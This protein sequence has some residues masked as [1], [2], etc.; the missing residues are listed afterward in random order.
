MVTLLS[1]KTGLQNQETVLSCDGWLSCCG[2]GDKQCISVCE[3]SWCLALDSL[4]FVCECVC[5]CIL[6]L[7]NWYTL[8][9]SNLNATIPRTAESL[10]RSFKPAGKGADGPFKMSCLPLSL[11]SFNVIGKSYITSFSKTWQQLSELEPVRG[12]RG[13]NE[14]WWEL[15]LFVGHHGSGAYFCPSVHQVAQMSLH[16]NGPWEWIHLWVLE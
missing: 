6:Q 2:L 5:V 13:G 8:S 16:P 9:M 3:L 7:S 15:R 11:M 1:S 12:N 4:S 10:L 14:H